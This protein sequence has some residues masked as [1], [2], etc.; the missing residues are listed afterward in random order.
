[1][2]VANRYHKTIQ[3]AVLAEKRSSRSVDGS[4]RLRSISGIARRF[5]RELKRTHDLDH[6]LGRGSKQ[7]TASLHF[8]QDGAFE[9]RESCLACIEDEHRRE[10]G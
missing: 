6:D 9:Q 4:R 10:D 8:F 3:R 7:E 5:I 1:M 2:L